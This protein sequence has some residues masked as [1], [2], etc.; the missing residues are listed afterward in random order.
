MSSKSATT[1]LLLE[2]N[3]TYCCL[4]GRIALVIEVKKPGNS[5]KAL[6]LIFHGGKE[7]EEDEDVI[8]ISRN[9]LLLEWNSTDC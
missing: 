3:A 2:W 6:N 1:K 8:E 7:N 5:G 9:K 4:K